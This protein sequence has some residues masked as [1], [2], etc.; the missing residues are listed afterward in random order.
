MIN[1]LFRSKWQEEK[2]VSLYPQ[3]CLDNRMHLHDMKYIHK[4]LKSN[5]TFGKNIIQKY[6]VTVVTINARYVSR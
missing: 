5:R 3:I 2:H 6:P 1:Y 4:Q